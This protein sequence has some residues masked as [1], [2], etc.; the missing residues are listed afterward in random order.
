MQ[1]HQTSAHTS[2]KVVL[3]TLLGRV[4]AARLLLAAVT[5]FLLF[6]VEPLDYA[7]IPAFLTKLAMVA[8][9]VSHAVSVHLSCEW[10]SLVRNGGMIAPRL[11]LS[12]AA[13]F[14]LWTGAIVAGR[15]VAS[16]TQ[17]LRAERA[18]GGAI[19]ESFAAIRCR[20]QPALHENT[21]AERLNRCIPPNLSRI[22]PWK[23]AQ[24]VQRKYRSASISE[25]LCVALSLG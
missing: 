24:Q 2:A 21:G 13:S 8:G 17:L 22:R 18:R 7:G 25:I 12:A 1:P 15:F 9:G 14:L 16:D 10:E 3:A 19:A 4:A 6:A 5:G 23:Q 20:Q 11:R